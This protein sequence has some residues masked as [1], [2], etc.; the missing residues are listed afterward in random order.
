VRGLRSPRL[1]CFIMGV[2][3]VEFQML[4]CFLRILVGA[5]AVH[6][7]SALQ[8]QPVELALADVDGREHRL[9]EYRGQWVVVNYW[10]TWCPPCIEEMPELVF[11]HDKYRGKG[12]MVIGVNYEDAPLEKVRAFLDDY[13]VSFPVWLASPD[14]PSPLGRIRG[15][16][17]TFIVSPEGEVVYTQHGK[18]TVALLEQLLAQQQKPR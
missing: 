3:Q 5:L 17:T 11:F 16:P 8:A 4:K 9:S 12:A 18:V 15:L 2:R 10:A 14:E 1:W 6:T 7:A 13:L